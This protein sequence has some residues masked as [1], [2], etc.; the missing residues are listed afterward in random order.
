M[1]KV[2]RKPNVT[3]LDG[4]IDVSLVFLGVQEQVFAKHY[5]YPIHRRKIGLR[6]DVEVCRIPGRTFEQRNAHQLDYLLRRAKEQYRIRARELHPDTGG[7]HEEFVKL[8]RVWE[9]VER[10]FK[11]WGIE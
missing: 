7:S 3:M 9:Y 5:E 6:H 10:R 4:K 2:I 8:T 11:R 1:G